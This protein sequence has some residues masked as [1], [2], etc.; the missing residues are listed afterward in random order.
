MSEF[1][2][3]LGGGVN[4]NSAGEVTT[5]PP[6]DQTQVYQIPTDMKLDPKA[7][8]S[9]LKDIAKLVQDNRL[10]E[11]LA[12]LG[13]PAESAQFLT[14]A[15]KLG[16][17]AASIVS[18]YTIVVSV[19][20]SV[21][22]QL[23]GEGRLSGEARAI[24]DS[25]AR[26]ARG[27]DIEQLTKSIM[28]VRDEL[29]G[30]LDEVR[31][32]LLAIQVQ[33]LVG[34]D[35]DAAIAAIDAR[36]PELA[37]VLRGLETQQWAPLWIPN[38][39]FY[40]VE[41][42]SYLKV[43]TA[44]GDADLS[45]ILGGGRLFDHRLGVPVLLYAAAAYPALLQAT[46]PAFRSRG[47]YAPVL[48]RL[49]DTIDA[50]ATRM[51][52]E[53]FARTVHDAASFWHSELFLDW[54]AERPPTNGWLWGRSPRSPLDR[55]AFVGA[56]DVVHASNDWFTD[57]W[58][59]GRVRGEPFGHVGTVNY[60]W[61]DFPVDESTNWLALANQEAADKL[62]L[63][64]AAAGLPQLLAAAARLRYLSTAP[65]V[66]ETVVG[67]TAASRT[68]DSE[69]AVTVTS[70]P[71]FPLR[72]VTA[73]AT[74]Q[75]CKAQAQASL[76]LQRPG[77][78]FRFHYRVGLLAFDS[79]IGKAWYATDYVGRVWKPTYVKATGDARNLRLT[80]DGQPN[81]VLWRKVLHEGSSLASGGT[82]GSTTSAVA[83]TFDWYVPTHRFLYGFE[84]AADHVSLIDT[85]SPQQ[86]P[87]T[88]RNGKP[89]VAEGSIHLRTIP[90]ASNHHSA[91]VMGNGSSPEPAPVTESVSSAR[92]ALDDGLSSKLASLDDPAFEGGERRWVKTERDLTLNWQT[93]WQ[94]GVL[95]V[96]VNGD[97]DDRSMQLW[98]VVEE[99]VYS[100][101]TVT[102]GANPL[103]GIPGLVT[104][105]HTAFPLELANQVT[106]VPDDFFRRERQALKEGKAL[107]NE[108]QRKYAKSKPA[109]VG[110]LVELRARV[111]QRLRERWDT[112]A[113]T[114]DLA[115]GFAYVYED[116]P[117]L[118]QE[119]LSE[120]GLD[121]DLTALRMY[122]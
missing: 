97:P 95:T 17:A 1:V 104:Q 6:D 120:Q 84:S 27:A 71:I 62:A 75:R 61:P 26:R 121:A 43:H 50:F 79:R 15:A 57:S 83:D 46:Q 117:S 78:G 4:L 13:A 32:Q 86:Q 63:L 55:K 66:S 33:G 59:D 91:Q 54:Q 25:V 41:Q 94:D 30:R 9:T 107:W 122:R 82:S 100:G 29:S 113:L 99:D 37:T 12:A 114:E 40:M 5:S 109:G 96:V 92:T 2:V 34:A 19:V 31:G 101:E 119:F 87:T 45:T 85:L 38:D 10:Q 77:P 70:G 51:D 3:H 20:F 42:S 102:E 112:A 73:S 16:A 21:I 105:I 89:K 103:D 106:L 60:S 65:L 80:D 88:G 64:Q 74:Q 69:Q 118:V 44:T 8:V 52:H 23:T 58:F 76:T 81:L 56:V 115:R 49:A 108:L 28:H 11:G 72:E 68:L 116:D 36:L 18:V 90:M 35:R 48:R 14:K 24:I 22:E 53:S 67:K 7:I 110:P 98:L 93:S 111:Q 47:T 39:Y